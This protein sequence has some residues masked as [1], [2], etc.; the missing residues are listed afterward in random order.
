MTY[1]QHAPQL[2]T[3]STARMLA[4]M[5]IPSMTVGAKDRHSD[6]PSGCKGVCMSTSLCALPPAAPAAEEREGKRAMSSSCST[7]KAAPT[8]LGAQMKASRTACVW[9]G[10]FCFDFQVRMLDG[11]VAGWIR[12]KKKRWHGCSSVH[13]SIC[14]CAPCGEK[15]GSLTMSAPRNHFVVLTQVVSKPPHHSPQH[16]QTK[17]GQRMNH[18]LAMYCPPLTRP[19]ATHSEPFTHDIT[20]SGQYRRDEERS[21]SCAQNRQVVETCVSITGMVRSGVATREWSRQWWCVERS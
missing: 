11:T 7:P 4:S 12:K 14:A 15:H 1:G 17:A 16:W 9:V 3:A 6:E 5:P 20:L 10:Q 2:D 8:A 21:R 13:A 19:Y 18:I